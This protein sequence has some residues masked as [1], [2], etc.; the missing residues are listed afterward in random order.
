MMTDRTRALRH[1]AL[2]A[3]LLADDSMAEPAL[4]DSLLRLAA[5]MEG[6]ADRHSPECVRARAAEANAVPA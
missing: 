2:L 5:C 3:R 6:E 4:R 1:K